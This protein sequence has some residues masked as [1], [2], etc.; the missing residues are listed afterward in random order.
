MAVVC[1][2]VT[3][4]V[5]APALGGPPEVH[6]LT[7]KS[8]TSSKQL[9]LTCLATGFYPPDVQIQLRKSRTSLPEHLVTSSGVRPNGDGT[10][11]LRKSVEILENELTLYNCYVTH[12]ALDYPLILAKDCK[13]CQISLR[14]IIGV[15]I[16]LLLL[17]LV[18]A[19]VIYI[20]Y[21]K[22]I[23][24]LRHTATNVPR[25]ENGNVAYIPAPVVR[26]VCRVTICCLRSLSVYA[27][28]LSTI[29][30]DCI[31]CTCLQSYN[32]T[33]VYLSVVHRLRLS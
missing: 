25:T 24:L 1:A 20:L 23:F 30:C 4:G 15:L 13:D 31:I 33:R 11:Q 21:F 18:V 3:L 32:A 26:S 17:L 2:F 14:E 7:K 16:S 12:S 22:G 10:Y 6:L 9:I 19:G 27:A 28:I 8:V 5:L 29:S